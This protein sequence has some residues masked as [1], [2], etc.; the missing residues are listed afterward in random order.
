M[1]DERK[2]LSPAEQKLW[3]TLALQE[4]M[5]YRSLVHSATLNTLRSIGE[6][7]RL[8]CSEDPDLLDSISSGIY[9]FLCDGDVFD[10]IIITLINT[11]PDFIGS[12]LARVEDDI[13]RKVISKVLGD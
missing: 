1:S 9:E 12:C 5:D 2:T 4:K 10:Q 3:D 11:D 8:R 13:A 7:C 6:I